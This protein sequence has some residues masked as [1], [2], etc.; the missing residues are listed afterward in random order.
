[1]NTREGQNQ[2]PREGQ[3]QYPRVPQYANPM[4]PQPPMNQQVVQP[5]VMMV[6]PQP[7]QPVIIQQ[8]VRE[9]PKHDPKFHNS[10]LN[11][12]SAGFVNCLGAF[13]GCSSCLVASARN[14][15][16]GSN[17]CFNFCCVSEPA[18]R[19]I[20]RSGYKINGSCGEDI[21]VGICC[22]PCSAIQL[23]SE[24]RERGPHRQ[25]MN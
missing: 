6:Q 2:Y 11:C 14:D 5:R 12:C 21:I 23:V 4:P 13:L 3:N 16:D 10:L 18:A 19:N 17:C 8:V 24:I 7:Q 22:A 15:Y 9:V 20:I 25:E 1:M